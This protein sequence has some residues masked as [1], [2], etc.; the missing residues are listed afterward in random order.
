MESAATILLR[1][2]PYQ[3]IRFAIALLALVSALHGQVPPAQAVPQEVGSRG[4]Y[5]AAV[6]GAEHARTNAVQAAQG[7]YRRIAGAL[8]A[9]S[10]SLTADARRQLEASGLLA[11]AREARNKAME[12]AEARY[13]G[14][15]EEAARAYGP[16]ALT[17]HTAVA[18]AARSL[19]TDL[20]IYES[21]HERSPRCRQRTARRRHEPC[22]RAAR[23]RIRLPGGGGVIGGS[24]ARPEH[25]AERAQRGY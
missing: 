19:R 17:L 21:R 1:R 6:E 5:A 16:A 4:T 25:R 18:D 2:R 20:Q 7:E 15:L 10:S 22:R 3:V 14:A 24:G 9:A 13:E 11:A 23:K 12:S 8:E